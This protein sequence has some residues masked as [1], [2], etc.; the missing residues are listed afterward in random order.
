MEDKRGVM[1]VSLARRAVELFLKDGILLK[2]ED[3][4]ALQE[5]KGVFV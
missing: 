3:N 5:K 1:L 2:P 4:P